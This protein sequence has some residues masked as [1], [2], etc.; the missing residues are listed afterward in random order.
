MQRVVTAL[1]FCA[2]F[3][4]APAPAAGQG[5]AGTGCGLTI[6][7]FPPIRGIRLGM[8]ADQLLSLFPGSAS[9]EAVQASLDRARQ[10]GRYDVADLELRPQD[11]GSPQAFAG[12][13]S[14]F[15][16][17]YRDRLVQF[18]VVYAT[19]PSD[20]RWRD[21]DGFI[22]RVT[23]VLQ[24]PGP[25]AWVAAQGEGKTLRCNGLE[26]TAAVRGGGGVLTVLDPSF[27]RDVD[28]RREA[29]EEEKRQGFEP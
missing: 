22:G 6:E 5:S 4:P 14:V 13:G 21:V 2:L 12:V 20:P 28:S 16:R 27:V 11:Y 29:A 10:P 7:Q 17:L 24:L 1:L 3:A 8:P 15:L 25:G 9:N 19:R 18:S 23:E 26:V